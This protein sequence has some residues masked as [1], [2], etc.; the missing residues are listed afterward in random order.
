MDGSHG[1]HVRNFRNFRFLFG[2]VTFLPA[3]D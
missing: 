2:W 3:G 1:E